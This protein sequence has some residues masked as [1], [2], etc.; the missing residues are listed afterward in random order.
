MERMI[1][2]DS[3]FRMVFQEVTER[4]QFIKRSLVSTTP[5]RR[6][7]LIIGMLLSKR[8]VSML[9]FFGACVAN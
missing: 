9:I 1:L 7:A 8:K 6:T 3:S 4:Q 2:G 5:V